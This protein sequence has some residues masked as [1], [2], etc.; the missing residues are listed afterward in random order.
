MQVQYGAPCSKAV[1]PADSVHRRGILRMPSNL[2]A[3]ARAVLE[4][5]QENAAPLNPAAIQRF[6]SLITGRVITSG[7]P[8]YESCRL[9]F[10]LAFAEHPVLIVRCAAQ[11]DVARTLDFVQRQNRQLAVRGGGHSRGGFGV[12]E[13]GIVLDLSTMKRVTVDAD[14]RGLCRGRLARP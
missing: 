5:C 4:S 11:S 6:A 1:R 12:C 9:I 13:G 10:T 8:N 3:E 7:A 2:L 14:K